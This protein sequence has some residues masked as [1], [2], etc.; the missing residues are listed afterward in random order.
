M[1]NQRVRSGNQRDW[2]VAGEMACGQ[3][4]D[5]LRHSID[6]YLTGRGLNAG[7]PCAAPNGDVILVIASSEDTKTLYVFDNQGQVV[8]QYGKFDFV[9]ATYL[10][11]PLIPINIYGLSAMFAALLVISGTYTVIRVVRRKRYGCIVILILFSATMCF[12]TG[13]IYIFSWWPE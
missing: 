3:L 11:T 4:D 9:R 8:N 13:I 2:D 6:N 7:R 1:Q 12:W 5:D 10:D